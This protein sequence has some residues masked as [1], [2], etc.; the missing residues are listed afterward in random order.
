[1]QANSV[2]VAPDL[3]NRL[4][5]MQPNFGI[6]DP[7][8]TTLR[9]IQAA[10]SRNTALNEAL[11]AYRANFAAAAAAA[12][13]AAEQAAA[14]AA[15]EAARAAGA[16][17]V[18]D[19]SQTGSNIESNYIASLYDIIKDLAAQNP[20]ATVITASFLG[21]T[22]GAEIAGQIVSW[23]GFSSRRSMD[24]AWAVGAMVGGIGL[25][26]LSVAESALGS[27]TSIEQLLLLSGS[28][29]VVVIGLSTVA[30]N[31]Y[32]PAVPFPSEPLPP[33][34]DPAVP[35]KPIV[36]DANAGLIDP[37]LAQQNA[38]I[39]QR[40]SILEGEMRGREQFD[41]TRILAEINDMRAIL[42]QLTKEHTAQ[43][44]SQQA[45][46]SL[47]T[48]QKLVETRLGSLEN[49]VQEQGS[50]EVSNAG[51]GF[52]FDDSFYNPVAK[53]TP[54]TPRS[55]RLRRQST[56]KATMEYT[57][58]LY[59]MGQLGE[60]SE[61]MKGILTAMHERRVAEKE[62]ALEER[63]DAVRQ[64]GAYRHPAPPVGDVA[65]NNRD[66]DRDDNSLTGLI[67][68]IKDAQFTP[69]RQNLI[70]IVNRLE[71]SA[72]NTNNNNRDAV[73][74]DLNLIRRVVEA[75]T[76]QKKANQPAIVNEQTAFRNLDGR[77]AATVRNALMALQEQKVEVSRGS[78]N[79]A[80][81]TSRTQDPS[82]KKHGLDEEAPEEGGNKRFKGKDKS[83]DQ[84]R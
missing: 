83:G 31:Y 43:S 44:A 54:S 2:T 79:I 45:S 48:A 81:G 9:Q 51:N 65:K 29:T 7:T 50:N 40:F 75:A 74:A 19:P 1:M 20:Q 70:D 18:P 66:R 82:S 5:L 30:N 27:Y 11:Q 72:K 3:Y 42:K 84:G 78:A 57:E 25:P 63:R 56:M 24:V 68:G 59:G 8:G 61:E 15:E 67:D 80:L 12:R 34:V 32:A 77:N 60:L 38:A 47:E 36:T 69:H 62:A 35:P 13:L 64:L 46:Q 4:D 52:D 41:R 17:A 76:G 16:G 55:P 6:I 73:N 71:A 53:P 10:L 33:V 23:A 39:E 49:A 28:V 37:A 26:M 22:T 58:Q 14:Q 21:A